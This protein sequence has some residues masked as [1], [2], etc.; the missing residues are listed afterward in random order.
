MKV[1]V[2]VKRLRAEAKEIRNLAT[3]KKAAGDKVQQEG[4]VLKDAADK[5]MIEARTLDAAA[6]RLE[7]DF[8][9][10]TEVPI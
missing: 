10:G 3:E 2:A 4:Q 8:P 7:V 6:D 5:E 9:P 1:D